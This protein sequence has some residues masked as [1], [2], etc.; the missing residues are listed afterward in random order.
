MSEPGAAY[1]VQVTSAGRRDLHRLPTGV[2]AAIVE[3]ITGPLADD[4]WRLSKPLRGELAD[5]RTARRGDYRVI[6]RIDEPAWVV[7]IAHIA[8][9]AH[10]YRPGEPRP[11]VGR[12]SMISR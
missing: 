4:P 1:H 7:L 5:Y 3:F 9:R 10:I 2:A 8:H 11:T 6:L 12:R